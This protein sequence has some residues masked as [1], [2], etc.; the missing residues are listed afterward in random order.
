MRKNISNIEQAKGILIEWFDVIGDSRDLNP[1]VEEIERDRAV[2][3]DRPGF[4]RKLLPFVSDVIT[5]E[6]YAGGSYLFETAANAQSHSDWTTKEHRVDGMLFPEMPWVANFGGFVGEVIGAVD[7]DSNLSNHAAKRILVWQAGRD[8][9]REAA[10]AIWPLVLE[11]FKD[12]RL[13]GAWL[14]VNEAENTVGLVLVATRMA[15]RSANDYAGFEFLR[16]LEIFETGA[17]PVEQ[18]IVDRCMWVFTIWLPPSQG[19]ETAGLWPNSPPMPAP[20]YHQSPAN[21]LK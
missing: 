8:A 11:A 10:G 4:V 12:K 21:A 9:A 19:K 14:G 1:I 17:P 20:D 7:A 3:A 18:L 2:Y 5:G 16:G 6:N 13:V 15:D